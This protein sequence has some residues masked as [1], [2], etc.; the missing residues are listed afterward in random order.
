MSRD[1][2][3]NR[4][5]QRTLSKLYQPKFY[6]ETEQY[7]HSSLVIYYIIEHT[8]MRRYLLQEL[9]HTVMEAGKSCHLPSTSWRTRKASSV[10]PSLRLKSQSSRSLEPCLQCRRAGE[11]ECLSSGIK[12]GNSTFLCLFVRQGLQGIG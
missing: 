4:V 2:V 8:Y 11:D 12:G 7:A 10:T 9:A 1:W 3:M 6:R 5:L